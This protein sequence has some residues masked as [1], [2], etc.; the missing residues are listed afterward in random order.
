MFIPLLKVGMK[1]C[2]S[3]MERRAGFQQWT[4]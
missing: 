3:V 1:A 2:V 4:C